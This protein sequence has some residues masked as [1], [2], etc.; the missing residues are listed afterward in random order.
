MVDFHMGNQETFLN[1][2]MF[3]YMLLAQLIDLY[4]LEHLMLQKVGK[5]ML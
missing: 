3:T 4:S 5:E 1:L 2:M